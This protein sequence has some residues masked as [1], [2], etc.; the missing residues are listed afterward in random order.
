MQ[1]DAMDDLYD[2]HVKMV[3]HE[4]IPM[5]V[6]LPQPQMEQQQSHSFLKQ[7]MEVLGPPMHYFKPLV[8]M[9]PSNKPGLAKGQGLDMDLGLQ[10][11]DMGMSLEDAFKEETP[12]NLILE[13]L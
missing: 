4:E 3:V 7:Q 1:Y 9:L 10:I 6:Q 11:R 12:K 5:E 13:N 2:F 8:I